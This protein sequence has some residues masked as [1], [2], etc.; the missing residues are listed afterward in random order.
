[1]PPLPAILPESPDALR[2]LVLGLR[3]GLER[4][5][6]RAADLE[7]RLLRAEQLLDWF[8]KRYYGPRADR[9]TSQQELGQLL[10]AFA[11]AL[12][13]QPVPESPAGE[14][15]AP[16]PIERRPGRRNLAAFE[17]VPERTLVYELSPRERAC[18]G[19]G[20]ER[21]EIGSEES[22]QLE[23]IPGHF[24]RLHHVRRKY[25]C[26]ACERAAEPPRI[27]AAVKPEAAIERGL[28]GPGLLAFVATSKFSDYLPLYRIEGIFERLGCAVSRATMSAWCGEVA[29]LAEPLYALMAE[30]VRQSHVLGTD[31]TPMPMQEPGAGRT[32]T[33]RMWI[34]RGD[35]DQPYNVF[36]FTE[37]R[38]RD[39]PLNWLQGYNQV[40]VAD[41]YGGYDGVVA[42]NAITRAGCWAH[43]RRKF[44]DAEKAAPEI[45]REAAAW[46][47]ALYT[48]EAQSAGADAEARLALRREQSLPLVARFHQRLLAWKGE[49][50]PKH[51]AAEAVGYALNQWDGL[52]VFLRDGAVPLDNNAC[53][54][55]IKRVVL[56]RK[57]SLFV[58]NARGGRTAAILSS[59][60]STCKR[61]A[62]DPQLYLTQLLINLPGW[63]VRDLAAWLPD[64]W[65][66]RQASL[67]IPP[68]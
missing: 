23:Y 58:G 27:E 63:P 16:R 5:E 21:S 41:A 38:K 46:I 35:E 61:H 13:R 20:A 56:N 26:R 53:E 17:A 64:H 40:R 60:T 12:D 44:V 55:E 2:T 3:A 42:G 32:R 19:C 59:L 4:E 49:L 57:N 7:Q 52:N 47:R 45:A 67:P 68:S 31:D 25:A 54:R 50:L 11:E 29:G 34:Y 62:V 15:A 24:E 51:P 37:S 28:P 65:K 39:G 18:P 48:V 1:M 9:L 22:W 43:A 66:L 10:L 30:R 33:A 8:R 6:R 14:P 36:D